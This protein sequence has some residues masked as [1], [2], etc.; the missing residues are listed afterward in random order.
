MKAKFEFDLPEEQG[1]YNLYQN[2]PKYHSILHDLY[3]ELRSNYKHGD[4][5][6]VGAYDLLNELLNEYKI[7]LFEE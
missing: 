5:K 4:G 1:D 2:A 6:L 3:Q 7:D